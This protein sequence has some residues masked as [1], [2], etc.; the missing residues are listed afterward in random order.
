MQPRVPVGGIVAAGSL[1]PRS[2]IVGAPL[3]AEALA[4]V[5]GAV[6]ANRTVPASGAG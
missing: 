6:G 2:G 5:C 3:F 4:P 1:A